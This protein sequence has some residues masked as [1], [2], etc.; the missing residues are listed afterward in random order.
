MY[1]IANNKED[2]SWAAN[3]YNKI[4]NLDIPDNNIISF[5]KLQETPEILKLMKQE[6]ALVI[7]QKTTREY[8]DRLKY[9]IEKFILPWADY[10]IVI[11]FN[12]DDVIGTEIIKNKYLI[13]FRTYHDK[14][15]TL[16]NI[17]FTNILQNIFYMFDLTD[18]L[19]EEYCNKIRIISNNKHVRFKFN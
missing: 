18:N 15:D 8:G 17:I 19:F 13:T 7:L 6:M 10:I 14:L 4:Y 12:C 1:V 9:L 16:S 3:Q 11:I 2:R 5:Y